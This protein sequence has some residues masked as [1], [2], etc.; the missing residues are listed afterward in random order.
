VFRPIPD[1]LVEKYDVIHIRHFV[2]VVKDNDP[3]PLLQNLCRMLKPGGW[4]QWDEWDVLN[5]HFTQA[6]ADNPHD[7]ID[8]LEEEFAVMRRHSP[9]PEWPPRLDEFFLRANLQQ[10]AMEKRLSRASHLPV[11]HDLTLL[12]FQE[13]IDGAE[14][15]E[16]IDAEKTRYL[17][18]L[19]RGATR[20][21]RMGVAWNLT[22]CMAI[23]QK[24]VD[25]RQAAFL[26]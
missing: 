1:E 15:K 11:M 9:R 5:R 26:R 21:S 4:L 2:C 17:R 10:V 22:R 12:V 18:G 13:L 19:L 3:A 7:C 14:M 6:R 24:F 8:K 20:E 16:L 23:G 25:E